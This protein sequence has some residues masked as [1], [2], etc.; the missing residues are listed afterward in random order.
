MRR[1]ERRLDTYYARG[2]LEI[3]TSLHLSIR[4]AVRAN[5]ALLRYGGAASEGAGLW[6]AALPAFV[7]LD[8]VV[9][10]R[11]RH[12]DDSGLR[13]RL[14][15]DALD[16]AFW[17]MSVRP[18]SGHYDWAVLIAA[19]LGVEAG[20][21]LGWRGLVV[22][23]AVF[24][25]VSLAA[26]YAGKAVEVTGIFWIVV[27]VAAGEAFFRYCRRL[28]DRAE[29]EHERV[30]VAARRRAYLAGQNHVAMGASSAVDAIEGL[31]PVLGRP[32][33]GSALWQLA[34]G[35]KSELRETTAREA[36]YLQVALLEWEK[37]HNRHPDLSGLVAVQ[38]EEGQGTT[39]LSA[40]QV[41]Q[42]YRALDELAPRGTVDVRLHDPRATHLPG[43]PL[44]LDVGGT[45]IRLPADRRVA[46]PPFDACFLGYFYVF[47]LE[48]SSVLRDYGGAPAWVAAVGAMVC[49]VAGTASHRRLVSRGPAARTAV[50]AMGIAAALIFTALSA[51]FRTPL[52]V[53]GEPLVD[54]GPGLL[55]L[56]FIGGFY[57][58]AL[59]R[60][61]V[62]I[63]TGMVGVVVVALVAFPMPSALSARAVAGAIA[64]NLFPYFPLRHLARAMEQAGI[65]HQAAI[66]DVD[67]GA[68]RAAF[69]SGRESVVGLVRQAREDALRQ[70]EAI[71]PSLD[72][73]LAELATHRLEEV[74]QRLRSLEPAA[75]SLS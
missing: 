62:V 70:L 12:S 61:Q 43:Q 55:L 36:G 3:R 68:E 54:L 20:V 15:L 22:P 24:A 34:D 63:L 18:T 26:L 64:Y 74:E 72:A 48:A 2:M 14:P 46:L 69:L 67:D 75:G 40:A 23:V 25:P 32:P 19:P 45:T 27:A 1:G 9:W 52:S 16:A 37:R 6:R 66:E 47:W 57:S 65:Q 35:W 42:L 51:F 11:L 28:D 58:W 33:G 59:G 56:S 21:R 73:R 4:L 53:E 49:V 8:L 71:R 7:V 44:A 50:I 39:L 30:M 38:V 31:V 17:T 60:R 10:Q 5:Q 13:W 41:D 29:I